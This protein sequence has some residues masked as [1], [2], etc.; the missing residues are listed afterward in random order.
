LFGAP[1]ALLSTMVACGSAGTDPTDIQE[2]TQ[3][4]IAGGLTAALTITSQTSTTWAGNLVVTNAGVAPANNWQVALNLGTTNPA[5]VT[6]VGSG[7]KAAKING[8]AVIFPWSSQGQTYLQYNLAVNGSATISLSGTRPSGSTS[9]PAVATV[10]GDEPGTVGNASLGWPADGK[11]HVAKA[12]ASGAIELTR[13]YVEKKLA[14]T[15]DSMYNWYDQWLWSAQAYKIVGDHIEFDPS[16]PGYAFIP[17]EAKVALA[18]MQEAPEVKSY[19]TAGLASCFSD[20]QYKFLYAIR[21]GVFK[22]V[23]NNTTTTGSIPGQYIPEN[24]YHPAGFNQP[25]VLDDYSTKG[26]QPGGTT[27]SVT[28]K[29]RT[30]TTVP[31][32]PVDYWFGMLTYGDATKFTGYSAIQSKFS[33]PDQKACSPFNGPGGYVNPYLTMSVNGAN[34][35]ARFYG[36]G[37]Q[38]YQQC[39]STMVVDPI[40]YMEL[41][42]AYDANNMQLGLETN[43]FTLDPIKVNAI[44]DHKMEWAKKAASGTTQMGQFYTQNPNTLLWKWTKM[45]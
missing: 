10:D 40:L 44:D 24:N 33:G 15:G 2:T 38:C 28:L 45:Y 30:T 7:F 23:R 43:P 18:A 1:L 8:Q 32:G 34:V 13:Q 3:N 20:T 21:T 22:G 26:I 9:L 6:T 16:T 11:D 36:V 25:N 31:A 35:P 39:T 19:I 37:Q 42:V 27:I 14:N 29:S 12:A 5:V 4:V 17:N 41:G